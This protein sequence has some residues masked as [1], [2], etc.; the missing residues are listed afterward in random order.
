VSTVAKQVDAV[1][2]A[3]HAGRS[4]ISIRVLMLDGVLLARKPGA[5]T[6]PR[7]VLVASAG[8][9]TV[10]RSSLSFRLAQSESAAE[11]EHFLRT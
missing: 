5:G 6:H 1:V 9:T 4:R 10:K 8:G 7:P 11:W 3:F 2:A